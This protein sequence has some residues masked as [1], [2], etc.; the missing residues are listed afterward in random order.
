[1]A[2]RFSDNGPSFPTALVDDMLEGKVVFL[3]GAGVSSPQLPGFKTLVEQV[4]ESLSVEMTAGEK[5]AFEEGRYEEVLGA[6]SRRLSNPSAVERAVDHLLRKDDPDLARHRT[7]LR[8]SRDL[9]NRPTLVTTNF[10]TLFERALESEEGEGSSRDLSLAGQALPTPGGA[11]FY[12]IIHLH[13]RLAD[14]DRG[15][16]SS[17]LVMTSSEYGDAYMRSAW[18]SRFLFDLVRCRTLVLV[19][20]QAGDAPVRY[21]L[22][23]L[24]ADRERFD[25]LQDVYAFDGRGVT[26]A[27]LDRWSTLAVDPLTFQKDAGDDAYRSLWRD[28]NCLA[29]LVETPRRWRCERVAEILAMAQTDASPRELDILAWLL[30]GK[31]DLWDVVLTTVVDYRWFDYFTAQKFWDDSDAAW[32]LASWCARDWEN[33]DRLGY[34]ATWL[35]RFG[36]AFAERLDQRI[37]SSAPK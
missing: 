32:V 35:A 28:L 33:R 18:A 3:C 10:D 2:I 25:D 17:A 15:L 30:T 37:A 36:Q 4:Y 29:D 23:V 5:Q 27:N 6:L 31:R 21:F 11:D 14:A 16:A 34:A 1:M 7:L 8:M 22:N 12:G 13:G 26:D 24:E 9:L 20:Y 19:G